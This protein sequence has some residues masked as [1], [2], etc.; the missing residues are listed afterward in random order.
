[1]RAGIVFAKKISEERGL[2]LGIPKRVIKRVVRDLEGWSGK[3]EALVTHT[4]KRGGSRFC[5]VKDEM[6]PGSACY[7]EPHSMIIHEALEKAFSHNIN[8]ACSLKNC[9]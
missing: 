1:M 4:E 6:F 3:E 9:S 2:S 5:G 8:Q 7:S